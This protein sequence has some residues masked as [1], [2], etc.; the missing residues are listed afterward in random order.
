[1]SQ[2]ADKVVSY[3]HLFQNFPQFVVKCVIT[4]YIVHIFLDYGNDMKQKAN[5][6]DFQVQNGL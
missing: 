1:M 6:S 4:C 3:S 5:V 2:E